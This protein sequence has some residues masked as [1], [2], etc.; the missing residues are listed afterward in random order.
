MTTKNI[1]EYQNTIG[2]SIATA[3]KKAKVAHVINLSSVGAHLTKNA[4]IVQGLHDQ[5]ERLSKIKGLNVIHLRAAYF[6]ENILSAAEMAKTQNMIG[7]PLDGALRFP[8]IATKDI[9]NVVTDYLTM[10]NF[11]GTTVKNLLGQ[12]DVNYNSLVKNNF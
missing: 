12:R 6:M 3:L 5:E 7:S 4:G 9:A 8:A 10:R 11:A 1:R 2:E